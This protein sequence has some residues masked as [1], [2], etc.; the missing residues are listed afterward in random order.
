MQ[1]QC[2]HCLSLKI[3]DLVMF[4]NLKRCILLFYSLDIDFVYKYL[5]K[6]FTLGGIS[7][8]NLPLKNKG[9]GK[10]RVF[11]LCGTLWE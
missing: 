9:K 8:E 4:Y 10:V 2:T 5:L 3:F 6:C 1:C 7:T 11:A